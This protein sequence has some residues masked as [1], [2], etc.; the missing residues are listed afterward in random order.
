MF[1][2]LRLFVVLDTEHEHA[3]WPQARDQEAVVFGREADE[4]WRHEPIPFRQQ[5]AGNRTFLAH[6]KYKNNNV[7]LD[8]DF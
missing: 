3:R 6:L 4:L 5:F 1:P 7:I 2:H 8:L